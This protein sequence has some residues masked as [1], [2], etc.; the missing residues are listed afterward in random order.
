MTEALPEGRYANGFN[1]GYNAFEFII[2]FSQHFA[3]RP[4]NDVHSRIITSPSYAKV[5]LETLR[6][7]IGRYE[8]TYGAMR[9][10]ERPGETRG[11]DIGDTQSPAA[12]DRSKYMPERPDYPPQRPRPSRNEPRYGRESQYPPERP[13]YPLQPGGGYE[14]KPPD[15]P[16]AYPP[17]PKQPK[18]PKT[19]PEPRDPY[20]EQEPPAYRQPPEP[21]DYHGEEHP[22]PERPQYPEHPEHPE[23]QESPPRYGQPPE[24]ESYGQTPT[25][26]Y[27]RPP[28]KPPRREEYKPEHGGEGRPPKSY[29]SGKYVPKP[30]DQVKT[31]QRTLEEQNKKLQTLEKQRNSLKDDLAGLQQTAT[32]LNTVVT[33]YKEACKGLKEEKSK[34]ALYIQTKGPMIEAG[35]G[36]QRAP[37][38]ECIRSIGEWVDEW[39]RYEQR[40]KPK[41]KAAAHAAEAAAEHAASTQKAY[42]TLKDSAKTLGEQLKALN[43]LRDQIE[44]EDDKNKIARMYFLFQ[45]LRGEM[46]RTR[47]LTPEELEN[48]LCVA[49]TE[50]NDAK[51]AAR[52][53]KAEAD[54]M[55]EA[56]DRASTRAADAEAKRRDLTLKCI[57]MTCP[58]PPPPAGKPC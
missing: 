28:G 30:D 29:E 43:A 16:P 17:P 12:G 18:P 49:W 2:D 54:A 33:N 15:E 34:L 58:P 4:E 7:S 36:D 41:A 40:L 55:R 53:A 32:E 35:I 31:L 25:P 13:E 27:G 57:D 46:S 24:E 44:Q 47:L 56:L 26:P 10:T 52:A 20:S 39:R 48:E 22:H 19:P 8:Q 3:E 50:L 1:I 21:P 42:D 23:E 37:V 6:E 5:L 9:G 11:G 14:Q 38:E 45:E 51:Q